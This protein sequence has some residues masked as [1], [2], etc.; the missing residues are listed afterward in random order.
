MDN[1]VLLTDKI[2]W[3]IKNDNGIN[4]INGFYGILCY[5]FWIGGGKQAKPLNFMEY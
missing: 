1:L 4:G 5:Y 3:I 2:Y